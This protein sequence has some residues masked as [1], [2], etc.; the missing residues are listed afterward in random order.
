[1]VANKFL[2]EINIDFDVKTS[3]VK[4]CKNFHTSVIDLSER[5]FDILQRQNYVTPTSYLELIKTFK[6]LLGQKQTTLLD[7]KNRYVVGLEKLDN[8][9]KEVAVMQVELEAL[10]P[11]LEVTSQE[12]SDLMVRIEAETVEVCTF[13]LW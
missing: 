9:S 13:L 3:I 2:E 12:T 8:A 11:Q 1:M 6:R 4:M 10:K 5:F 7:M